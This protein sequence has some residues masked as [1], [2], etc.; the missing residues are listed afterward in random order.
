M[1]SDLLHPLRVTVFS[2]PELM[3]NHFLSACSIERYVQCDTKTTSIY[4]V[5]LNFQFIAIYYRLIYIA[6]LS[7]SFT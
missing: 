4:S 2:L 5:S 1:S 3:Q 7:I 6:F